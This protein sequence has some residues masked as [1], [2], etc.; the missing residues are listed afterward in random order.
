MPEKKRTSSHFFEFCVLCL[1]KVMGS[2][3]EYENI[4]LSPSWR[5]KSFPGVKIL[6]DIGSTLER[7]K[8]QTGVAIYYLVV[9]MP[10]RDIHVVKISSSYY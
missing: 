5:E 4:E 6:R 7:R 2:N 10:Y 1:F 3:F 9:L 8:D